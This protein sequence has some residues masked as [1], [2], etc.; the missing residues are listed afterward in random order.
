MHTTA[1]KCGRRGWGGTGGTGTNGPLS[2]KQS[3]SQ[4]LTMSLTQSVCI[5]G[6]FGVLSFFT[7]PKC[8]FRARGTEREGDVMGAK[9]Q[10][11]TRHFMRLWGIV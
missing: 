4:S 11:D 7:G 5:A 6:N 9:S 2:V 3:V 1:F 8:P 10:R